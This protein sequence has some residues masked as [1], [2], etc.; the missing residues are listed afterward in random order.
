[1]FQEAFS[2]CPAEAGPSF[3]GPVRFEGRMLV[4]VTVA[5]VVGSSVRS[6]LCLQSCVFM[7]NTLVNITVP[8]S[9]SPLPAD[10]RIF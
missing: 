5:C 7:G 10:K 3:P 9:S 6:A 8:A 2:M 4:S 1:M